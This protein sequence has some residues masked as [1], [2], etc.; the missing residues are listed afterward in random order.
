MVNEAD[1]GLSQLIGSTD[2]DSS[3]GKIGHFYHAI[4]N[5]PTILD[6]LDQPHGIWIVCVN[7][8]NA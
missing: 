6:I 2:A 5:D 3:P 4:D 7:F 8:E 1:D